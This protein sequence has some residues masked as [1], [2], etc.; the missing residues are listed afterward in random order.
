MGLFHNAG[1][2]LAAARTPAACPRRV[3]GTAGA[4]RTAACGTAPGGAVTGCAGR[5]AARCGGAAGA[6]GGTVR[7]RG[8]RTVCP[9]WSSG[10]R[11][12]RWTRRPSRGSGTRRTWRSVRAGGTGRSR[13]PLDDRGRGGGGSQDDG[14][15]RGLR[16]VM[17][18]HC[19]NSDHRA[20]HD[21]QEDDNN[22]PP[23]RVVRAG[24]GV[25]VWI[26]AH[27]GV[28]LL[29]SRVSDK[30]IPLAR[31]RQTDRR[32]RRNAIRLPALAYRKKV[33]KPR[34]RLEVPDE[35]RAAR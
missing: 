27:G 23:I 14:L 35:W 17:R 6:P 11:R 8:V 16:R 5:R 15:W 1:C 19:H 10:T 22:G 13:R 21:D 33:E 3:A 28:N 7:C 9:G 29:K 12:S 32:A 20:D 18:A 24:I 30:L 2:L 26:D 25:R 34:I 31:C 4:G